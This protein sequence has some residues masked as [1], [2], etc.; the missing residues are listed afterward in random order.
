MESKHTVRCQLLYSSEANLTV[1]EH[2]HGD[3]CPSC[4]P[5]GPTSA[6]YSHL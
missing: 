4:E 1:G 2:L 6:E 5:Q 3:Y